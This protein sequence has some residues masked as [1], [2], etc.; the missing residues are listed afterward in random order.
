MSSIQ[1]QRGRLVASNYACKLFT[2]HFAVS[3]YIII[4]VITYTS[5]NYFSASDL[6]LRAS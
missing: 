5:A 4:Y 1:H 2:C 6:F 3:T